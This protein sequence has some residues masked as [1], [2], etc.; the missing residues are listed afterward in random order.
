MSEAEGQL[1]LLALLPTREE[2]RPTPPRLTV[3]PARGYAAREGAF[4]EW[5]QRYG[6]FDSARVSHGWHV[7][8]CEATGPVT[9]CQVTVLTVN[10]GCRHTGR[11]GCQC[12]GGLS[13]R[14]ACLHCPWEGPVRE[15]QTQAVGDGL[16]HAHPGWRNG[17]TVQPLGHEPSPKQRRRWNEEVDKL[18]GDRPEGYP[19][20]TERTTPGTRA[21]PG[22]SPWGGYDVAVHR[23]RHP[24][25]TRLTRTVR[26]TR[27][28]CTHVLRVLRVIV[29]TDQR[30]A[31]PSD[32][33][34]LGTP[35]T[36]G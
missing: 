11:A 35:R 30:G 7:A 10:L 23:P 33:L 29:R 6:G 21:V 31:K 13:Y 28:A 18:Y 22:R 8:L 19:I 4:S 12:V 17:P 34:P 32:D 27:N 26:N 25:A 20:I 2:Q 15:D 9:R 5:R 1:D 3:S 16:D 14:G 24:R 36:R